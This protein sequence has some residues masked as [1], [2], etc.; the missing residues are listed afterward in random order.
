MVAIIGVLAAIAIPSYNNYKQ[1]AKDTVAKNTI[2]Q[3]KKAFA[4]CIIDTPY[5]LCVR[6][7]IN[8]TL[9]KQDGVAI[10]SRYVGPPPNYTRNCF[11]VTVHKHVEGTGSRRCVQFNPTSSIPVQ[12]TID[13]I[14]S[15]N[16]KCLPTAEC[17]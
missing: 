3:I 11:F 5:Y 8:K 9:I 15:K 10:Q 6:Y 7:N 12:E 16:G 17:S 14:N 13:G 1:S 4:A 2:Y